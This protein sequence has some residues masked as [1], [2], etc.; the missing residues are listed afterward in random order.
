M[1]QTPFYNRFSGLGRLYGIDALE[2]LQAAHIAVIGVGGVGSWSA[3][4]LAR[5]GIGRITLIDL[6]DV[7]I[8]NTNRQLHAIEGEIGRTKASATA[9]RLRKINPEAEIHA[10]EDYF[11][12]SNADSILDIG[13][14]VVIDGIDNP[15]HKCELLIRCKER[16]I[17]LIVSGGAGGKTDPAGVSISD[18]NDTTNDALLKQM[19]RKLRREYGFPHEHNRTPWGFRAVYSSQNPVFPWKDGSVR[20]SPEPG[21]HLEMNCESGYGSA[22]FVTGTFGFAAAAEAVAEVLRTNRV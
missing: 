7:C 17:P 9:D 18:L 21:S 19:R 3:E 15:S 5:S 4:A 2:K 16:N 1:E 8:T 13:F 22:S 10:L 11:L 12:V 6:D 14:D 20:N